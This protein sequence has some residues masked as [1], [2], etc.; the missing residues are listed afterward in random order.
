MK[1]MTEEEVSMVPNLVTPNKPIVFNED[2]CNGCNMCVKYCMMD[3]L[4][5][6]PEKG[7]PPIVLYPD[8]CWYCGCCVMECPIWEKEPTKPLTLKHPMMQRVRWK[9]KA[10]GEHFRVGM[11]NPPPP[12]TRPPVGGWRPKAKAE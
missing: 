3:V 7:K 10:T 1:D 2:V 9:R 5:P 8:E 6:N 4:Y 11:K 12:N